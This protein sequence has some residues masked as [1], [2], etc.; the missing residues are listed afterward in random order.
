[1][2]SEIA[3]LAPQTVVF[4]TH[5]ADTGDATRAALEA[6]VHPSRAAAWGRSAVRDPV[7]KAAIEDCV[8]TRFVEAGPIAL[9]QLI[10]MTRNTNNEYKPEIVLGAAKTLL[11]RAGYTA[12]AAIAP[13]KPAKDLGE[14]SRDEVASVLASVE[15]ELAQRATDIT[16]DLGAN[17]AQ[18]IDLE[19]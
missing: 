6:G 19:G 2:A 5:F 14:M 3:K 18:V 12:Q 11:D 4:V 15:A 7:V 10:K 9:N 8:R 13:A 17:L 1:M 16:P